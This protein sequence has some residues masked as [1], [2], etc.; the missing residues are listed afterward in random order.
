MAAVGWLLLV[1]SPENLV[2]N[3]LPALNQRGFRDSEIRI[4]LI[5]VFSV[6]G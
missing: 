5:Y 3:N 4:V 6:H 2:T 1:L